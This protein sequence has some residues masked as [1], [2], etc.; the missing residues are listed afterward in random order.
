MP[1]SPTQSST[2]G[3]EQ[4]SARQPLRK[5]LW[6]RILVFLSVLYA[7]WC[8]TLFFY[9]DKMLFQPDLA[10]APMP[11][12]YSD[13]TVELTRD[14]PGGGKVIAWFIPAFEDAPERHAPLVIFFHGNAEIIDHQQDI[15]EGY[16]RLGCS[17]LLPEYRGY[18]RSDGT[19]SE[20]A[21]VDDAVYFFDLVFEQFMHLHQGRI[22]IHGRS[23]GGAVAA[24]LA[25]F[26]GGPPL[27]LESTF[28]SVSDMAGGYFVPPIIVKN[29]FLT[30][31]AVAEEITSSILI[32]HGTRD[33]VIPV[34]HGRKLRDVARNAHYVE[35]DCGHNDFP[36]PE[37]E[38]AYWNE[39][40]G[41]LT[42]QRILPPSKQ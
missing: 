8:T 27:I 1:P 31:R 33:E 38:Q 24:Q 14:I 4:R 3:Y 23:L 21:I 40:K 42:R 30:D 34:S 7:A 39:I 6:F 17:I 32:L 20:E 11:M 22:V 25:S 9:Q 12:R 36:G 37:N 16:R 2:G 5:R 29:K 13:S 28:T 35:Y 26:R 18:G 15:I 19:P 41:F 10:A